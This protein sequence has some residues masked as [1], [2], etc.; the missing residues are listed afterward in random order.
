MNE[1]ICHL[2][3]IIGEKQGIQYVLHFHPCQHKSTFSLF[4]ILTIQLAYNGQLKCGNDQI[5]HQKLDLCMS[6]IPN[7]IA[8]SDMPWIERA[9][10]PDHSVVFL[11]TDGKGWLET[12]GRGSG[13]P[14]NA[15]EVSIIQSIAHSLSLCG[16]EPS[17]IG[18]ITPFRS[19]VKS[20]VVVN[21]TVALPFVQL[22]TDF[23][24]LL[25]YLTPSYVRWKKTNPFVNSKAKGLKYAP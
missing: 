16:L 19:Q 18:V 9:L 3:N 10:N 4:F 14:T 25:F 2:S 23:I 8:P 13:G 17:S 15:I 11:D 6:K 20:S 12:D 1:S 24:L 21:G 7:H 22:L 5:R